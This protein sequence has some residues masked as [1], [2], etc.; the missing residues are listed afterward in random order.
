MNPPEQK[1]FVNF[2]K[3]IWGVGQPKG[4]RIGAWVAAFA[5]F[6]GMYL[7]QNPPQIILEKTK[8]PELKDK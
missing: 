1:G 4:F 5:A 2:A 7:I 6:G 8:K 3:K